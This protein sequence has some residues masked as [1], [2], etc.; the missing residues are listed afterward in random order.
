[1]ELHG[2]KKSPEDQDEKPE[3][4]QAVHDTGVDFTEGPDLEKTV[5][6]EALKPFLNVV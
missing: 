6:Q 5:H 3:K 1:M 4:D 2:V